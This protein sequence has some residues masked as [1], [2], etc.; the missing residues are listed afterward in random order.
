MVRPIII[1]LKPIPG[2]RGLPLLGVMPEM[3]NDM[4]GLFTK[5]ARQYGG[6]AQFKLLNSTYLLVTNPDY[7][8]YILQDNYKNYI[9]GRSVETGRVLL[10]NGLP[11]IDGD[12][13]LHER[14]LLQPAFHRERLARLVSRVG[15]VIGSFLGAWEQKAGTHP[16]LDMQDEM[17]QLT[18]AV[19]IKSMFRVDIDDKIASLS[20][21]FNVASE[22]MLWR[23]QQMWAPPLSVPTTRNREYNRA[24]KTLN[25]TIYPLIAEAREHPKNDLLG[26]LLAMRD[27]DTGEGMSDQQARDE[28]V[29]M[30]F[31]G[32]ETTAA[33]LTW[34]FYLLATHPEV[35][36]Q[37]REEIWSVLHGRAPTSEE[38]PKLTYMQQVIHESLRLY[39]AAYLFAREALTDDVIDGYPIPAK[40][41]IFIT[42][43]ITHRNP[44]YWTDPEQFDPSRFAPQ[45]TAN[46]P[47][48]VYYP[49][50]EGPHVCIGNHFALM[51]MQL[52]LAMVFQRFQL[53]LVPNQTVALKPE[54]T[55]RSK[56]GIRMTVETIHE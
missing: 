41:L 9:R 42:P 17:M 13:W 5:T 36:A 8:K 54:A 32:H 20:H 51:E 2:P 4:L 29:T 45:Y 37:L 14:R 49:F 40:T 50:G 3:V 35:E 27:E 44:D 39:P 19:I 10:G 18:L 30:F 26:M 22:F 15:G 28:V 56:H 55:L 38:L 52:I 1:P 43:Y 7:V 23:S 48:H 11:L 53:K 34:A 6:I 47:R 31:A 46:R 12:F 16:T 33:S 21:A 24:L 25:D